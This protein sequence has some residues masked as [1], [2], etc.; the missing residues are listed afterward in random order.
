LVLPLSEKNRVIP[1]SGIARDLVIGKAGKCGTLRCFS[2]KDRPQIGEL[3][4]FS[5]LL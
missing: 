3:T 1:H 4:A 2:D 5:E